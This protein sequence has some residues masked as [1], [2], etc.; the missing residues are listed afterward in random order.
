MHRDL[1]SFGGQLRI[2]HDPVHEPRSAAVRA[3]TGCPVS[4]IS[5]ACFRPTARVSATIGVEQNSL[6]LCNMAFGRRIIP[7]KVL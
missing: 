2:R 5:I 1:A 7:A 6:N 4:S 3:S